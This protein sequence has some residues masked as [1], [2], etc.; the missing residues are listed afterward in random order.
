VE[1]FQN[2]IVYNKDVFDDFVE[3]KHAAETQLHVEHGKPLLFANGTRGLRL[4]PQALTLE[5]VNIKG[6]SGEG[7]PEADI[8]VHDETNR[9]LAQL[10][11]TLPMTGFPMPLGVIYRNPAPS[12]NDAF[13]AAHASQGKRTGTVADALRKG[14]VWKK[15]A[16]KA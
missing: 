1:I 6:E 3:K 8:L 12:F 5:I 15:E 16:V 10:L 14:G 11:L 7:V 4:N 2:C 9:A 13:W